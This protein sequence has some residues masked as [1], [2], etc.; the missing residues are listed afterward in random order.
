MP[1]QN[2]NKN[3][4]SPP[5]PVG[6]TSVAVPPHSVVNNDSNVTPAPSDPPTT[7]PPTSQQTKDATNT[8]ITPP[9]VE[10]KIDGNPSPTSDKPVIPPPAVEENNQE[11]SNVPAKETVTSASTSDIPP[12]VTTA[13]KKSGFLNN[14]GKKKIATILGL[15]L[16]VGGAS[17]GVFLVQQNQDYR[18]KAA[19]PENLCSSDSTVECLNKE[20]GNVCSNAE[21]S[22]TC[23]FTSTAIQACTCEV[24][25]TPSTSTEPEV[26]CLSVKAYSVDEDLEITDNNSWTRLTQNDLSELAAGDT[27]YFTITGKA[28][29]PTKFTQ[30]KFN[31]IDGSSNDP[32]TVSVSTNTKPASSSSPANEIEIYFM[33][34]I[35]EDRTSFT[36][37]A[38][39]YHSERGWIDDAE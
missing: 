13:S 28:N 21:G 2:D 4:I 34:E 25:Y 24:T 30:A 37:K 23:R 22:G 9:T 15:L 18:E 38:A 19:I 33:Y 16:L 12:V 14:L 39:I 10:K 17:T 31:I 5:T 36:V 6:N 26:Q 32:E 29:D 8:N 20:V 35:P 11:V 1:D 3:P 27:V 7:P